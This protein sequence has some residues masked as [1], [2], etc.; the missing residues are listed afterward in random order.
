[1]KN[2]APTSSSHL[3][4]AVSACGRALG[5]LLLLALLLLAFAPPAQAAGPAFRRVTSIAELIAIAPPSGSAETNQMPGVVLVTA[6]SGAGLWSS[7][8]V[9]TGTNT[10]TRLASLTTD[11]AW[12]AQELRASAALNFGSLT[13]L[14][15][16]DLTITV[17]GAAVQDIVS[18]GLPAAPT[19]G[20]V[21]TAFVSATDTVTV[22][23][24]NVTSGTIDPASA[25]YA[26]TV[27]K[28]GL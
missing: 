12:N 19:A 1:M 6:G 9:W 23:A 22:R 11:W 28:Q 14:T 13:T 2:T 18:L 16:A 24:F 15:S 10:T 4:R 20:I 17:T 7:T 5:C 3:G 21:F 8:N 25:T 27:T 26:V